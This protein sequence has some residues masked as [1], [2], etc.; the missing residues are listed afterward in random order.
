MPEFTSYRQRKQKKVN[1]K[2]AVLR[3]AKEIKKLSTPPPEYPVEIT[4]NC[5]EVTVKRFINGSMIERDYF[6]DGFGTTFIVWDRT[7]KNQER[8]LG[9]MG[10]QKA[11]KLI[12][13]DFP[14]IRR[15]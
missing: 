4:E 12:S 9:I 7:L 5:F 10:Q 8:D 1:A 14:R 3:K 11:F 15:I 2:M 6:L 13:A